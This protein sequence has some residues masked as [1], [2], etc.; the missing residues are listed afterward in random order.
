ML[1]KISVIVSAFLLLGAVIALFLFL[2]NKSAIKEYK[3]MLIPLPDRFTYTAHTGCMRTEDNSLESI[4]AAMNSGAD[5]IEI[6]LNFNENGEPV[7]AHDAPK[8]GEV[9]LDEAFE[10]IYVKKQLKINIDIKSTAALEKVKPLAEKYGLVDRIFF[11]GVNDEFLDD[12]RSNGGGVRYYLNV[13]V[14]P[15][16]KQTPEYLE[17]LVKKVK[18]SGAIGINFNKDNATKELVD[19]FRANGLLVSIWTVD[20]EA[21]MY[22]ILSYAPDNITTRNPDKLSEALKLITH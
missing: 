8:G 11:T 19:T 1:K 5:I 21:D 17:S 18:D 6:D 20:S 12:V 16:R 22:R 15:E 9:T 10:R 4:E 3:S 7:L 13:D 14:E 2:N